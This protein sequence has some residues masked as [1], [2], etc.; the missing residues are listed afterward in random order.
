M[1]KNRPS[2]GN[3]ALYRFPALLLAIIVAA[4]LLFNVSSL[5]ISYADDTHNVTI[6]DLDEKGNQIAGA[7]FAVLDQATGEE[8]TT[9]TTTESPTE[10]ALGAGD[11]ILRQTG[12]PESQADYPLASDV[13]FSVD[14][15]GVA[16]VKTSTRKYYVR[17]LTLSYST[18]PK[19]D[20]YVYE[21]DGQKVQYLDENGNIVPWESDH[22]A[23]MRRL[24]NP[25]KG[26][27]EYVYCFNKEKA[28]PG[29]DPYQTP[30]YYSKNATPE[31]FQ[32]NAASL[33]GDPE[34]VYKKI[35]G[36]LYAGF[37]NN[38]ASLKEKYGL[39]DREFYAVTQ[40]AVWHYTDSADY[41]D[42]DLEHLSITNKP[43]GEEYTDAF[44]EGMADAY[45]ELLA[46]S[47][48]DS[49]TV[50]FFATSD[51]IRENEDFQN[52]IG[53]RF[54][55]NKQTITVTNTPLVTINKVDDS[56]NP[57][58]GAEF[59]IKPAIESN[60]QSIDSW[61]TDG[62]PLKIDLGS[63]KVNQI[64]VFKE[65]TVPDGYTIYRKST[66]IK[67]DG[68]NLYQLEYVS[69]KGYTWKKLDEP[70]INIVNYKKHNVKF[71]KVDS[72]TGS[73]L[74]GAELEL[75]QKYTTGYKSV[76][77]WTTDGS[78]IEITDLLPGIYQLVEK[79]APDGY[80]VADPI[81]FYLYKNG[82]I[83]ILTQDGLSDEQDALVTMKDDSVNKTPETFPVSFSKIDSETGGSLS[84]AELELVS[85]K[86]ED[87]SSI[88]KWVSDGTDYS[89][90]GLL[91]GY[92][93]LVERAA[94]EGY[95]IA[96]P[97][98]FR[99][100]ES[101]SIHI[102]DSS[103]AEAE[104]AV[105]KVTMEDEEIPST[106]KDT[107]EKF[108]VSFRKVDSETGEALS[109][110]TLE[111]VSGK[112]EDG[113]SIEKW[114][115]D[116]TDHSVSDLLPGYYTLVERTAPEGYDIA[117]PITFRLDE[118]GS[119]HIIDSSGTESE[120]EEPRVTMEDEKTPSVVEDRPDSPDSPKSTETS[121][122][123]AAKTKAVGS[124]AS[125]SSDQPATGDSFDVFLW[126]SF[127]ILAAAAT[128]VL[129]YLRR[130]ESGR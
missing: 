103:G 128:G 90:S 86:D 79:T 51:A 78:D 71:R 17:D 18:P 62:K 25:D 75:L 92:Y 10:L 30:T 64:Y 22:G 5:E 119:I 13:E 116:G 80:N 11:Y 96:D 53:A 98:T 9:F 6:N 83:R 76:K 72:S 24:T 41:K 38:G 21:K 59:T 44:T 84:G 65:V 60:G 31:I 94:P 74:K 3:T 126:A 27:V 48:D 112:D 46:C 34:T 117:D 15:N 91:P 23:A 2:V 104:T 66:S 121:K 55:D 47:Y 50:E 107:P 127:L 63:L 20:Q 12:L 111:L 85:G 100:D 56:G 8:V 26:G 28:G 123:K 40:W 29:N 61:T 130:K 129:I 125:A 89:V 68:A 106:V 58:S 37:P 122:T 69:G 102:I 110:A 70:V 114:V 105:S 82:R 35:L 52:L 39:T 88:E 42:F 101:G 109:G 45:D 19:G 118:N 115:S 33:N 120:A 95:G 124:D 4:A 36:V 108:P 57:V 87:G 97:I 113:S 93:T 1:K 14:E 67:T 32:N 43:S 73:A 7:A 99:L 81:T 54:I 49:Q 77:T 16:D